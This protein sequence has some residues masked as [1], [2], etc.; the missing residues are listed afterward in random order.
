MKTAI[1]IPNPIFEAAEQLAQELGMSRSELYATALAAY[2]EAHQ[3][4]QVT[5][6]LN[7]VYAKET[8]TIDPMVLRMQVTTL[9]GDE[10]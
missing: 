6:K 4:E 2:L 1:S 7:R 3:S 10:W 8:S 9:D 5:E